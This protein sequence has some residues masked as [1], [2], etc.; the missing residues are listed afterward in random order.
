MKKLVLIFAGLLSC[1][2]CYSFEFK[3]NDDGFYTKEEINL[4]KTTLSHDYVLM[5]RSKRVSKMGSDRLAQVRKS[6]REETVKKFNRGSR[7]DLIA[8]P[9]ITHNI[10]KHTQ[11][12]EKELEKKD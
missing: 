2:P 9:N 11:A 1:S 12:L 4:L 6:H 8:W 3:I 10:L 5:Q 7:H